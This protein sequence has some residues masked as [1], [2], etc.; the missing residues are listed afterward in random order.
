M[1][2]TPAYIKQ[3]REKYLH[4]PH[5]HIATHCWRHTVQAQFDDSKQSLNNIE[6]C[7]LH[8]KGFK[9]CLESCIFEVVIWIF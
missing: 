2:L 4:L 3:L 9:F 1:S 5:S 7:Q 6:P 8:L